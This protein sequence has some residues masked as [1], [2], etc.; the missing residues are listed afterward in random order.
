MFDLLKIVRPESVSTQNWDRWYANTALWPL[1]DHLFLAEAAVRLGRAMCFPWYDDL[2]MWATKTEAPDFP[3]VD[4]AFDC[5][6]API[7][8][9][10]RAYGPM[11]KAFFSPAAFRERELREDE[12]AWIQSHVVDPDGGPP[13]PALLLQARYGEDAEDPITREHWESASWD[14][15]EVN[16][17]R[18][19]GIV[20]MRAVA[21]GLALL[22][23]NGLIRT[24]SR[25]IGGG[26]EYSAVRPS[27]WGMDDPVPRLAACAINLE[28]PF[29][30][31]APPT[32]L[33]FVDK[34]GFDTA[35]G[36]Y[37]HQNGVALNSEGITP[38]LIS[39]TGRKRQPRFRA[40]EVRAE[41]VMRAY[42]QDQTNINWSRPALRRA[43]E[44]KL[45]AIGTTTFEYAREAL[46][47]E[48]PGLVNGGA[49]RTG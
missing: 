21:H 42:L 11:L 35:I 24:V 3:G 47:I 13:L 41:A 23:L 15:Q 43:V 46:L 39:R 29:A 48:F 40:L 22:A 6:G 37:A 45:G 14:A 44:E 8:A 26:Q 16:H 12:A 49:P 17:L 38:T 4:D 19:A 28:E 20:A 27:L 32:H 18:D 30:I 33:L 1:T 36:V 2:P 25:P 31:D 10:H 7:V 9:V 34:F 5:E